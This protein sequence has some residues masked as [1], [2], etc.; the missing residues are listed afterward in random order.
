MLLVS[1]HVVLG[2]AKLVSAGRHLRWLN[3]C[4]VTVCLC[5]GCG[6]E[7]RIF[8]RLGAMF[9]HSGV[10]DKV[11]LG[12]VRERAERGLGCLES[13]GG[14]TLQYG[15]GP[16]GADIEVCCCVFNVHASV[17]NDQNNCAVV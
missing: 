9:T 11:E 13:A 6:A 14:E 15:F 3:S 16:L 12:L 2:C 4:C 10:V 5:A 1:F 17:D 7:R 8:A